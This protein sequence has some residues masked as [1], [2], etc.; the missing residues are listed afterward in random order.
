ME[1]KIKLDVLDKVH[2]MLVGSVTRDESG[3][4]GDTEELGERVRSLRMS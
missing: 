4:Y 1:Y 3:V 2:G